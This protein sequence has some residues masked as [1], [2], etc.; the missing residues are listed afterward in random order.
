MDFYVSG[1]QLI[2][3][4]CRLPASGERP[5]FTVVPVL[6]QKRYPGGIHMAEGKIGDSLEWIYYHFAL[7]NLLQGE[8]LLKVLP[9]HRKFAFLVSR[10]VPEPDTPEYRVSHEVNQDRPGCNGKKDDEGRNA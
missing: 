1:A 10:I 8:L 4:P 7:F 9:P 5:Q 3:P 2:S 6:A